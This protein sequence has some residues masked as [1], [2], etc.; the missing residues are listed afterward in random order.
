MHHPDDG[1]AAIISR[2]LDS[3]VVL[4]VERVD[5]CRGG[6]VATRMEFHRFVATGCANQETTHLMGLTLARVIGDLPFDCIGNHEALR[7]HDVE[8]YLGSTHHN[9]NEK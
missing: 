4:R 9:G 3:H 8:R 2:L 1:K 7:T 5:D 6:S